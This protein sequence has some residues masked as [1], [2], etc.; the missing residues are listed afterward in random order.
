MSKLTSK[1]R[2]EIVN[3]Y[4]SASGANQ[5]VPGEF[6]EWL[7]ERPDHPAYGWF[8][9]DDEKAGAAYRTH[10]ARMFVHGLRV[11]FTVET[12]G[13]NG[14]IKVTAL[15]MPAM[16]SPMEDRRAGGGYQPSSQD[17]PGSMEALCDE[18]ARALDAWCRRYHA[19]VAYRG[20]NINAARKLIALLAPKE[21]DEAA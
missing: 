15:T 9:W 10:Q 2:Q 12:I 17:D 14:A 11:N 21:Q 1:R 6:V 13:R 20:G 8:E 3:E 4:L 7:S 18:A 19:A 16:L 5:Y